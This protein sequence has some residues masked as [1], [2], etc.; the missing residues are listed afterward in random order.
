MSEAVQNVPKCSHKSF[1]V[2]TVSMRGIPDGKGGYRDTT[3]GR[4]GQCRLC[5]YT[6]A[7]PVEEKEKP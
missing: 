2:T 6:W 3:V 4:S 5:G 7:I 1:L